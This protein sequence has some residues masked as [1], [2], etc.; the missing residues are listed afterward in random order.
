MQAVE[1]VDW[2]DLDALYRG[3]TPVLANVLTAGLPRSGRRVREVGEPLGAELLALDPAP[4]DLK[5]IL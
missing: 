2:V 5:V 1:G 4:L 3:E